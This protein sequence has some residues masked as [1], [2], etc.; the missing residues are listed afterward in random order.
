MERRFRHESGIERGCDSAGRTNN[1]FRRESN[2]LIHYRL[3]RIR[4]RVVSIRPG[5][6]DLVGVGV[7]KSN[8]NL[9]LKLLKICI[10]ENWKSY[11]GVERRVAIPLIVDLELTRLLA[12]P[13]FANTV[14]EHHRERENKQ[15]NTGADA[16]DN[17]KKSFK[18]ENSAWIHEPDFLWASSRHFARRHPASKSAVRYFRS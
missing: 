11:L 3:R 10:F 1:C 15:E 8:K 5:R 7:L 2:V 4:N 13:L 12:C 14:G 16:N 17:L 9:V 18:K 6:D